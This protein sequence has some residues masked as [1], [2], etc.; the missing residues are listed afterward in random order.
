MDRRHFI[1]AGSERVDA[2][3]AE[4]DVCHIF[5]VVAELPLDL[6]LG[7]RGQVRPLA[8]GSVIVLEPVDGPERLTSPSGRL[9]EELALGVVAGLG[10]VGV[11]GRAEPLRFAKGVVLFRHRFVDGHSLG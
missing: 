5:Y 7:C 4:S 8:I 2:V 6:V 9:A 3:W 1:A 11:Y 10:V